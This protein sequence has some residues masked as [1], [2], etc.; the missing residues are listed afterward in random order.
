MSKKKKKKKNI[1]PKVVSITML[2]LGVLMVVF[3]ALQ[4]LN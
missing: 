4:Y 3:G 1:L 2:L